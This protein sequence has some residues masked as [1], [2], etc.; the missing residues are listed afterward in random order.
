[1]L[2]FEKSISIKTDIDKL[3]NFHRDPNNLSKIS[4][5][6][7][8]VKIKN[9]SELPLQ[10]DSYAFLD[11]MI[12]GIVTSWEVKIKECVEPHLV[13]DFQI[14]GLFKYWL[15]DHIFEQ[16]GSYVKMTDRVEYLPPFGFW[17]YLFTPVIYL[18]L[19]SMFQFRHQKTKK[20]FEK[21]KSL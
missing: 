13:E 20:L 6:F 7:V 9:I 14:R 5:S 12:F 10:K 3:F 8:K 17:G 18:V 19:T 1:M 15:H 2:I 11:V 4:P 16:Q 21:S